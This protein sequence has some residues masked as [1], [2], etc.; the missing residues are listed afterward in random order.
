MST[1]KF[2]RRE[3]L[4]GTAGAIGFSLIGSLPARALSRV[5]NGPGI[6]V[7]FW[8]GSTLIPATR[9]TSGDSTL[10]SLRITLRS[11]GTGRGLSSIDVHAPVPIG[12]SIVKTPFIAWVAPPQGCAH[13]RFVAAVHPN[14][15]LVLTLSQ[16]SGERKVSTDL[17]LQKGFGAAPKLQEGTY[18]LFAGTVDLSMLRFSDERANGALI[19]LGLS[20]VPPQY[21]VM[22][23][24]RA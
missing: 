6:T 3:F 1:S 2:P 4:R 5:F 10:E 13:T 21:V 15:G 23:I 14:E 11:Y 7:G 19:S 22:K 9:I 18:V 20:K 12:D 16:G 24:E 17:A 8:N